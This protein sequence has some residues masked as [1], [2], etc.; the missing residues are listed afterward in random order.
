MANAHFPVDP[1]RE[2]ELCRAC[3]VAVIVRMLCVVCAAPGA[4][5]VCATVGLLF[6]E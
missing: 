5:R 4:T 2:R 3:T 1:V 6:S